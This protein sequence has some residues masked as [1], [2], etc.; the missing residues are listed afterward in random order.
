MHLIFPAESE[1]PKVEGYRITRAARKTQ[2]DWG[3]SL[4]AKMAEDRQTVVKS[5]T[6][7]RKHFEM[8]VDAV[9]I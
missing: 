8:S 9:S 7:F 1:V 5:S 4:T 6:R 2:K 3:R